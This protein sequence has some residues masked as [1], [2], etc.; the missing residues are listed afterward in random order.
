MITVCLKVQSSVHNLSRFAINNLFVFV[1]LIFLLF[2]WSFVC[3]VGG[4]GGGGG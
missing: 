3:F 2:Y 1:C 4:G